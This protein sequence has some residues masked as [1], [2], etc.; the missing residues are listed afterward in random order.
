MHGRG[1][2]KVPT[3]RHHVSEQSERSIEKY[4]VLG[5]DTFTEAFDL[6]DTFTLRLDENR[7]FGRVVGRG[8]V[9]L[10]VGVRR[11]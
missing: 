8:I 3:E 6:D 4:A 1:Y 2:E 7:R 10:D 5:V 11:C 9:L